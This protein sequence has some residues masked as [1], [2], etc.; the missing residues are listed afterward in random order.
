MMFLMA[1]KYTEMMLESINFENGTSNMLFSFY[2]ESDTQR[3]T[4]NCMNVICF[5]FSC[6]AVLYDELFPCLIMETEYKEISDE[7]E[8]IDFLEKM[9]YGFR[10]NGNIVLPKYR[11]FWRFR[12]EGGPLFVDLISEDIQRCDRLHCDYPQSM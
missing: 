7:N 10:W 12:L 11:S 1:Q 2:D 3:V 5:N 8:V 6:G 9:N 4:L